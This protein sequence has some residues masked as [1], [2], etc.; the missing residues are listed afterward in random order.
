MTSGLPTADSADARLVASALSG[1]Q[2][3]VEELIARYQR[4]A[5]AIALAAGVRRDS[6]PDVLQ[7]AFVR[8]FRALPR[9]EAYGSYGSWFLAI[10]RNVARRSLREERRGAV[11]P[12]LDRLADR[13]G[14]NHADTLARSDFNE[15]SAARS[16]SCRKASARRSSST[17]YE[18]GESVRRVRRHSASRR[19]PSRTVSRGPRPL[20]G[21]GCGGSSATRYAT[22]ALG[23]RG[24]AR[25]PDTFRCSVD[26]RC[27]G[28][29]APAAGRG[30]RPLLRP[31][32]ALQPLPPFSHH[33]RES[34]S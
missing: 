18:E 5:F 12:D 1:N 28:V 34:S 31:A 27:R 15:A 7:D 10:V 33:S 24:A 4:K 19:R 3:A 32:A 13:S 23:A 25:R 29:G 11:S 17:T 22:C 8:A 26:M 2:G 20:S 9:L 14:E 6:V 21:I 16:I 30:E